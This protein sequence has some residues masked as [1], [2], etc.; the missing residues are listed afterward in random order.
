MTS[1]RKRPIK[2]GQDA[3]VATMV[4]AELANNPNKLN[5]VAKAVKDGSW[6]SSFLLDEVREKEIDFKI[7]TESEIDRRIAED[8]KV[9]NRDIEAEK[10]KEEEKENQ[11]SKLKKDLLGNDAKSFI[12]GY[13]AVLIGEK[14]TAAADEETNQVALAVQAKLIKM[15]VAKN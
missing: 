12:N 2:Q 15:L 3:S 8:E 9:K 6:D 1:I 10:L 14:T 4:I 5:E 7:E 13:M 11:I